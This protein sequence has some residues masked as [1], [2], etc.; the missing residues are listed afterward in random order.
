MQIWQD[1]IKYSLIGSERQTAP[2][3][4][5]GDLQAYINQL[6]PNNAVPAGEAREQALLS[7]AA[8]VSQYRLAGVKA[9]TFAS[10]LPTADSAEPL[11]LL[12]PLAVSHLQRLL[13]DSELKAVLPEWLTLATNT[14]HRVPFALIPPL[15]ELA[16]QNRSIR[17]AITALI[18]KRGVWLAKQHPEWQKL[19]VQT[20]DDVLANTQL[21][22]EGNPAERE[23]F[24]RQ[25]RNQDAVKARELLESVW[26]QEP[27]ATRQSFLAVFSNNLSPAD[28]EFLNVCLSDKSKNVRQLA[29]TLLGQLPDSAFSQRQKQRLN[30]WLR[31]EKGGLLK[32]AKLIVELPETWDKT[33]LAD[34]IEE[35]PP[36]GKGA[37]AWWLEQA[38]SFVPPVY[39]SE[40][41]QLSPD[42]ILGL[43]K[44][45][46]WKD[47]ILLAWRQALQNYPDANWA[48]TFLLR[49]N[50]G[51]QALWQILSPSHAERLATQL[52]TNADARKLIKILPILNYLQHAWSVEFS[53]QVIEA[54]QRYTQQKL[55]AS[56]AYTCYYLKDFANYLAPECSDLFASCLQK[57][58]E[59]EQIT[60]TIDKMFFTLSFRRD[61]TNALAI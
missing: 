7:A 49:F 15:L 24:L 54:L 11:P 48:E 34:G 53:K 29:A 50:T 47:S 58:H 40:H 43:L 23:E 42:E 55:T 16:S 41:W 39:W 36:Q 9:A 44:K 46:D 19:V 14:K 20:N 3:V 52:L 27:A 10:T 59:F 37:K 32:K 51:E 5:D 60:R 28:E 1:L 57:E 2:L 45:H 35:K 21:W 25:C 33:W 31:F 18:D 8:L 13:S 4:A 61:M 30:T 17:P 12:S 6:Y 38:L 22:E 56:E 26:K